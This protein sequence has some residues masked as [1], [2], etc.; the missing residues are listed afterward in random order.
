MATFTLRH[1]ANLWMGFYY[2]DVNCGLIERRQSNGTD[3]QQVPHGDFVT[4]TK[5][6]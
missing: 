3:R 1:L 6:L 5:A 4:I 2:L